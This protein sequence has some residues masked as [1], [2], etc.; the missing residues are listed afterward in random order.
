MSR[1]ALDPSAP[2]L[3]A[4]GGAAGWPAATPTPHGELRGSLMGRDPAVDVALAQS[5]WVDR[6]CE[7]APE[8]RVVAATLG[9][10]CD[11]LDF[12]D[13]AA[14]DV[15]NAWAAEHT[16]GMIPSVID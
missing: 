12:G 10:A 9:V 14:P 3:A 15:V 6:R 13:P 11:A 16:R 7:L 2:D 8:F 5:V 4:V 1:V